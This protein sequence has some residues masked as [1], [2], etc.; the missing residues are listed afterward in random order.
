MQSHNLTGSAVFELLSINCTKWVTVRLS[1][2][3]IWKVW[4][5]M[6]GSKK[7]IEIDSRRE[8]CFCSFGRSKNMIKD[9][10]GGDSGGPLLYKR[11]KRQCK[12]KTEV[13]K[14]KR[15][16]CR[17][18][19]CLLGTV[20][21]SG[22]NCKTGTLSKEFNGYGIWNYVP[23]MTKAMDKKKFLMTVD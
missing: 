17:G 5:P 18:R 8:L 10:C 3:V 20:L 4:N 1:E 15:C 22:Y 16:R 23:S 11:S 12:C 9:L 2:W 13:N 6:F 7:A 21:G 14:L 19:Y